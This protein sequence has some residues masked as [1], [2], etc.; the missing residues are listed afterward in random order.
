ILGSIPLHGAYGLKALLA[1]NKHLGITA[2][3]AHYV[4][5]SS[6][7]LGSAHIFYVCIV[8]TSLFGVSFA[9]LHF[10]GDGLKLQI[11]NRKDRFILVSL[12]YVPPLVIMLVNQHCFDRI[13]GFSGIFVAAI[14]G[15]LPALMAW[16]GRYYLRLKGAFIVWGGKPLLLM[17]LIFFSYVI[18]L[19]ILNCWG[20]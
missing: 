5:K 9:L 3:L 16:R 10:L 2:S 15:I 7:M 12:T 8:L 13:L 11:K 1:S 20:H 14:L 18:V 17:T 4:S 6:F 19:E